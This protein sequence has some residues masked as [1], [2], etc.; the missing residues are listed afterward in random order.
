MGTN[1]F[2]D[3]RRDDYAFK[4][5]G[6]LTLTSGGAAVPAALAEK[7]WQW[8]IINWGLPAAGAIVLIT[9]NGNSSLFY[10][11]PA[12][13]HLTTVIRILP[14]SDVLV[15]LQQ[16]SGGGTMGAIVNVARGYPIRPLH[17]GV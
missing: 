14:T 11:E 2:S 16:L 5:V 12:Q 1:P 17:H 13:P 6:I 3:Q 4:Y 9:A 8:A 10:L 7:G 15:N